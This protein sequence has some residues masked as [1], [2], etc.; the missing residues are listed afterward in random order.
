[1]TE[2]VESFNFGFSGGDPSYQQ[3]FWLPHIENQ[4]NVPQM[5]TN[6]RRS[7][8]EQQPREIQKPHPSSHPLLSLV[9]VNQT[10]S[11]CLHRSSVGRDRSITASPTCGYGA[12]PNSAAIK[13]CACRGEEVINRT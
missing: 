13:T 8:A 12:E 7:A 10:N 11:A 5:P 3:V 1:M 9:I 2:E 6:A 4:A